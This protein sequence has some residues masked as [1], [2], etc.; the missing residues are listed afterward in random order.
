MSPMPSVAEPKGAFGQTESPTSGLLVARLGLMMLLEFAVFGAWFA[1]LGLVLSV[2]G[3]A[4]IIGTAY[5]LSAVAAI[6]SPMF[7][8][9]LGD[10]CMDSRVVLGLAHLLGGCVLLAMPALMRSGNATSVLLGIFA[11]MLLFQ[12]T[13][14]VINSIALRHVR[15]PQRVFPLT[16]VFAP[17]GW[18]IAGLGVGALHLSASTGVFAVAGF[19]SLVLAAYAFTLPATPPLGTGKRFSWGDLVGAKAM[20]LFRR[21]NFAV[22]MVCALLTSISLG[23]YNSFASPFLAALGFSNVAGVLAIGQISEVMFI[24]TIPLVLARIGMKWSLLLGMG[25]WGI[26]FLLFILAAGGH[27]G[28]AVIGIGLHGICNDFFIVIAALYLSQSVPDA[29]KVQAQTMLILVIS[30]FGQGIGSRIA[31]AIF[32]AQVAPQAQLAAAWIPMWWVPIVAA[33]VTTV[34]WIVGFKQPEKSSS[35]D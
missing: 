31:G 33:T 25:L 28:F 11:Y 2:H 23:V 30:G 6:V 19:S 3:Y 32:A 8:G 24:V 15:D 22:L 27:A 21:R 13:L 26:R 35:P 1:T 4:N 10:R 9:A 17:I 16:R 18:V 29:L 20:V 34:T 5:F 14:G 7:L 12:P